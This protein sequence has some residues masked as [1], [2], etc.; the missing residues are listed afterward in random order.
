MLLQS[1]QNYL[2]SHL[3]VQICDVLFALSARIPTS[4]EMLITK[5]VKCFYKVFL[6]QFCVISM[7]DF[8]R[9]EIYEHARPNPRKNHRVT[10]KI[11]LSRNI[12]AGYTEILRSIVLDLNNLKIKDTKLGMTTITHPLQTLFHRVQNIQLLTFC[13]RH[14]LAIT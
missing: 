3:N 7:R 14:T 1:I 2:F 8:T 4:G 13:T 5:V 6:L 10:R 12:L 9:N 11:L